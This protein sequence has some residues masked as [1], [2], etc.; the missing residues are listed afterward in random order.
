MQLPAKISKYELLEFLGGG[1]SHVYRAK[2]TVLGRTVA[3]KILTPQGNADPDARARF[4]QEARMASNITHDNI[5]AIFDFGEEQGRPYMVMEFLVGKSLR[6]LIKHGQTGDNERKMQI[7]LQTARALGYIH[8]RKIVHRDVKPE[9]IHIEDSSGKVKLMDF[10]IAKS[11]GVALTRVG[12]TLGT[13]YYMAPEQVLGQNITPLVDIYAFGI[14][15][16]ELITGAKPIMA[17]TVDKIFQQILHEPLNLDPLRPLQ[18]PQKLFDLIAKCTAK[19]PA[20]RPPSFDAV[21]SELEAII[22]NPGPPVKAIST[23]QHKLAS[24]SSQTPAAKP[25]PP[26]AKPAPAPPAKAPAASRTGSGRA[27]APP[28]SDLPG[29]LKSLPPALQTQ[30]GLMVVSAVAALVVFAVLYG[31]YTLVA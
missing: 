29:V 4:L 18:V 31:I 20:H 12:F 10:G 8:N 2:D 16:F 17:E 19:D 6:D 11:E 27:V 24:T 5:I 25:A 13:P 21:V 26:A 1:M 22:A 14:L 9:N 23:S 28:P 7:A 30:T 3:V 15:F